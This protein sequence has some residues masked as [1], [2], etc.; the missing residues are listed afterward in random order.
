M[1][2]SIKAIIRG[3]AAP[4][5]AV[6]CRPRLWRHIVG[7]IERRGAHLTEA[8]AF[9]V[10]HER[11]GRRVIEDAIYYDQLDPKAYSSGACILHGD[12]FGK[13]WAMCAER[14]RACW[15]M[16][17]RTPASAFRAMKTGPTRWW[18]RAGHLAFILPD[19]GRWPVNRH[20]FGIY[21]YRGDHEWNRSPPD[22][23]TQLLLYWLLELRYDRP[24]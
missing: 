3:F 17:I 22:R 10:G 23:R 4:D 5:H 14:S 24:S 12:S 18:A 11:N 1:T 9:L 15:L 20:R 21:E 7:E 16:C 8:G 19:F 6:S 13:L 2:F